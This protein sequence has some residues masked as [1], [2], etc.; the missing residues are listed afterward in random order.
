MSDEQ[1]FLIDESHAVLPGI[2]SATE[3]PLPPKHKNEPVQSQF[4]STAEAARML[5]LSTTLVQTLVDQ[6]NSRAGKHAADT[7]AFPWT[8]S[9][10]IKMFRVI[11]PLGSIK[12]LHVQTLP[13]S[14]NDQV[15]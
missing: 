7:D 10:T 14:L 1:S 15:G 2:L 5:G 13:W 4:L 11:P 3:A 6:G 8:P 12:P 9:W